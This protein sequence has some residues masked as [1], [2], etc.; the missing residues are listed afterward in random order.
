MLFNVDRL[1]CQRRNVDESDGTDNVD[2]RSGAEPASTDPAG[3][4][5]MLLQ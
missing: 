3:N 4:R 2:M 1:C 5:W